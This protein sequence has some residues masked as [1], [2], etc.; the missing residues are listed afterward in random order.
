MA[1]ETGLKLYV[2]TIIKNKSGLIGL[3]MIIFFVALSIYAV[4]SFGKVSPQWENS[5]YWETYPKNAMPYWMSYFNPS[6]IFGTKTIST[7]PL[8]IY[9]SSSYDIYQLNYNFT[10]IK[11]KPPTDVVFYIETSSPIQAMQILW[12]KPDGTNIT[13]SS[14]SPTS[15]TDLIS[16]SS[17]IG[18]YISQQIGYVPSSSTSQTYSQ[19]LFGYEGKNLLNGTVE[20]GLYKVSITIVT[21]PNTKILSN[22]IYLEG[23]AYG[24][25]GTDIYGRPIDLGILLGFPNALEIGLLTSIISVIGGV[26]V[27]G[28]SGF[29]GGKTDSAMNWITL[30]ILVLPALPFL[31]VLSYIMRPNLFLE[32]LLIAFL[33]WPFYAIIARSSAQSIKN[34]TFVE[35]DKVLGIPSYRIFFTHF[36]PRLTP[37]AIA[38]TALGVPAAIILVETL[39]FLG[40]TPTGLVT[41]GSILNSAESNLA[42]VNGWWWWI[43]FP[44][45]MIILVSIPFVMIGFSIEKAVFG[46]K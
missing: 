37:F 20:K 45:V 3:I 26:I 18:N 46:G 32:A 6:K 34:E 13:L 40:L 2:N 7:S 25:F 4:T 41:W 24:L 1:A 15:I 43:L 33:S 27:G 21:S 36:L 39:A 8:S 35:A 29:L 17:S 42:A 16:Y 19:A 10:W 44:G 38:Y 22:K 9:S 5:V 14:N 11:D 31:V 12:T 30:V 28:I 23:N